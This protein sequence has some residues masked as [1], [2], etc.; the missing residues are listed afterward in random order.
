MLPLKCNSKRN[1][2]KMVIPFQQIQSHNS[3]LKFCIKIPIS[4][5]FGVDAL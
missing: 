5:Q 4:H 2:H 3:F 1:A